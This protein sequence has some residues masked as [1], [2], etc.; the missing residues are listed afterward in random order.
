MGTDPMITAASDAMTESGVALEAGIAGAPRGKVD[1][2]DRGPTFPL[3]PSVISALVRERAERLARPGCRHHGGVMTT[4]SQP[5]KLTPEQ[6]AEIVAALK[7]G[8]A[9][10]CPLKCWSC[11]FGECA[12]VSPHHTWMSKAD[13]VHAQMPAEWAALADRKPCGCHCNRHAEGRD[14]SRPDTEEEP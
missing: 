9:I 13:L 12:E 7:S 5:P 4:P 14:R 11:Q 1:E 10:I 8:N 3:P 6:A 2:I